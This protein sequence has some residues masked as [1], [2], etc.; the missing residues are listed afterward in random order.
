MMMNR[1]VL[2][3]MSAA[4]TALVAFQPDHARAG[5]AI[6]VDLNTGQVLAQEE[7]FQPVFPASLTKLMTTYVAFRAVEAGELRMDSPIEITSE[8]TKEPPSKM[9][10][11]AG[12]VLTLDNAIKILMVKS[13]NDV[14]T[15]IAINVGGSESAFAARMNAEAQRIGMTQSHFVNA[16][17]LHSD[18]QHTSARDLAILGIALRRDFPQHASYFELDALADGQNIMENHNTLIGR[19]EGAD[20]MKTGYTCPSGFNLVATATKQGRSLLAVVIGEFSPEERADKAAD[21]LGN[22]FLHAAGDAPLLANLQPD[23]AANAEP[24]NLRPVVCTEEAWRE[25]AKRR[26]EQGNSIY[27]SRFITERT[28]DPVAIAVSLGGAT[29]P[30]STQPRFANVPVPTP[31]PDYSPQ[32]MQAQG[33]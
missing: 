12:S 11:A 1:L 29:G 2:A 30:R 28:S 3:T 31:R 27:A 14:A 10:Y 19:F 26:D 21:L 22:G 32:S 7:A 20:G 23:A 15:A 8:A 18:R 25:R 24:A 9:G 6:L 5:P 4:L 17:G 33:G 13:A 16:H